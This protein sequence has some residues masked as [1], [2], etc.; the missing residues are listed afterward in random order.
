MEKNEY[1]KMWSEKLTLSI[2]DIEKEFADVLVTTNNNEE[3]ALKQLYLKYKN[4]LRTPAISFEGFLI[5]AASAFDIVA[6]KHQEAKELFRQDPTTAIAQGLT[7]ESGEALDSRQAFASGRANPQYGK[8]LPE[9]RYL[10]NIYGIACKAGS[11]DKPRFF[12]MILNDE[13][14]VNFD[15]PLF[16][17]VKFMAIDKTKPEDMELR[18]NASQFTTFD[19]DESLSFGKLQEIVKQVC[20]DKV[21]QLQ[22]LEGHH[23]RAKDDFNRIAIVEADVAQVSSEPTAFGSRMMHVEDLANLENIEAKGLTCWMPETI[24][25]DFEE[26]SKVLVVGRTAQGK[27]KDEQG[28]AT[29]ELGDVTMNCY[30]VFAIPEYKVKAQEIQ[31]V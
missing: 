15:T 16:T 12:Q 6:R 9:H 26:G 17:G 4:M 22:E 7:N 5:G 30:G 20:S 27:K 13:K 25:I 21:V 3:A 10:R 28:N 14:A 29:E 2:E 8:P 1:F 18:L 19:C 23:S 24:N 31:P 11:E